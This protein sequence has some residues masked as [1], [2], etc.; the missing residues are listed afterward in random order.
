MGGKNVFS[1]HH[2]NNSQGAADTA[3][4]EDTPLED[5]LVTG[6]LEFS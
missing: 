1:S 3:V 2:Q 4:T 5:H 6:T